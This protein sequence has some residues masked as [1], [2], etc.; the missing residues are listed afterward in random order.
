M[1][2]GFLSVVLFTLAWTFNGVAMG[3]E[4]MYSEVGKPESQKLR[5]V[6]V[7]LYDGFEILDAFG[8]AEALSRSDYYDIGYYSMN[9]GVITGNGNTSVLTEPVSAIKHYEI[10]LLPGGTGARALVNDPAFIGLV[11]TLAESSQYVLTVCTGSM[12]LGKTGLLDGRKATTNKL[13]YA[14]VIKTNEKVLWQ[15][16]ARWVIDGKYYTS[17]GVSAGTD[18]SIGFIA[19]VHGLKAAEEAAYKI[20]YE[21]NR[22]SSRDPFRVD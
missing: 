18:M 22:D 12:L 21:W 4:H 2:K 9:G 20:E 19:D 13:A 7:L 8:P 16:N 14:N 15:K 1:K 3:G 11:K 5:H 17:S 10:L 6:N